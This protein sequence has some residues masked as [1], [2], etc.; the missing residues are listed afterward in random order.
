MAAAQALIS[1]SDQSNQAKTSETLRLRA[2][3]DEATRRGIVS[4][5]LEARAIEAAQARRN[6]RAARTNAALEREAREKGFLRI[7]NVVQKSSA[8]L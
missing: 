3:A 1:L 6:L 8:H 5:A 7:A 4:L 2:I